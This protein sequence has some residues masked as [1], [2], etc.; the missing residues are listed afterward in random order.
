MFVACSTM[1][2]ARCPLDRAL[3]IIGELEF[4]KLDVAVHEHGPHLKPSEVVAD[5][6][7]A[8]QRIRI[9]PSL[10]PAA[11]S[12]EID[13]PTPEEADRQM[14]AVCRLARMSTVSVLTIAAAAAGA[15]MDAEVQRLKN[16]VRIVETQGLVLT[17]AT[18]TGTLTEAPAAAVHLCELVPGLGL[19]LDP[20]HYINGPHQG[21]SYDEVFPY[22]RHVHLRDTGRAQGRFQV[23]VGQGE[24]E[25]G[26]IINQLERYDYER[27]LS[28]SIHDVA[29]APFAMETEVRKLK[30][31]LE[32]LV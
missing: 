12:V 25:Y 27:L 22:V 26:R 4:S 2:F 3:R 13:A 14:Q 9:G 5:V 16:L 20:S 21:A 24:V 15:P 23:R 18:R 1:C 8:L 32:S 10:T 19:T 30:Y 29:E 31:L 17:V 11:F 28:V 7:A 6:S